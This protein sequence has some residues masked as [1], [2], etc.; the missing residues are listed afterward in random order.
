MASGIGGPITTKKEHRPMP[1]TKMSDEHKAALAEGRRQGKAVRDYLAV[2]EQDRRRGPRL[3][4]GQLQE[5]IAEVQAQVDAEDDPVKRLDLVQKRLDYEDRLADAGDEV[6]VEALEAGF[7]EVAKDY[8]DRKGISYTAWREVGVP[9]AV[10]KAA[11]VPRT[12][13]TN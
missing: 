7:V 11:G 4:A 6:D 10:L 13:R 2:I 9:A 12:R 1:K 5:R 8:G 3:D